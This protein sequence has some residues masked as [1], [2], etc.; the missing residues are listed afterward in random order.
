MGQSLGAGEDRLIF[1]GFNLFV[2][3]GNQGL[4]LNPQG[5]S[6]GDLSS[7]GDRIFQGGDIIGVGDRLSCDHITSV[8][9]LFNFLT[10]SGDR[11]LSIETSGAVHPHH[12]SL[13]DRQLHQHRVTETGHSLG[14]LNL[15][16]VLFVL[17][18]SDQVF[19]SLAVQGTIGL[20]LIGDRRGF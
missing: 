9:N 17:I 1:E 3:L 12:R 13:G 8:F 2:P 20:D 18:P 5:A 10:P 6:L 15:K 4:G 11:G 19:L 14:Q 16:Q 7:R